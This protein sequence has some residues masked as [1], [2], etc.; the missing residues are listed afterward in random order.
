[1]NIARVTTPRRAGS[2][3]LRNIVSDPGESVPG[4]STRRSS[5]CVKRADVRVGAATT[6]PEV[7]P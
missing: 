2:G 5:I 7:Y 6:P 1:L 3:F 4:A